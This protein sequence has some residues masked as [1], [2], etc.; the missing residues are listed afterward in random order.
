MSSKFPARLNEINP[1]WVL[2]LIIFRVTLSW[3][4]RNNGDTDWPEGC[5]LINIKPKSNEQADR[6]PQMFPVPSIKSNDTVTV[7]VVFKTPTYQQVLDMWNR[8]FVKPAPYELTQEWAV[9][10]TEWTISTADNGTTI[11]QVLICNVWVAKTPLHAQW[12]RQN[13]QNEQ[14]LLQQAQ[15]QQLSL[16]P[17]EMDDLTRCINGLPQ[18]FQPQFYQVS[19]TRSTTKANLRSKV[20]LILG[21]RQRHTTTAAHNTPAATTACAKSIR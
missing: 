7:N 15:Q 4:L 9:C 18:S 12:L 8:E 11:G 21:R 6:P 16:P 1:T 10:R 14:M 3:L 5:H 20:R 19:R 17:M 13:G 2:T